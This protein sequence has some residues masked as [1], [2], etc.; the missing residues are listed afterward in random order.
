MTAK[1]RTGSS[2]L[3]YTRSVTAEHFAYRYFHVPYREDQK[4][5][6]DSVCLDGGMRQVNGFRETYGTGTRETT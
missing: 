1:Y 4:R 3:G 6:D 5:V 2:Q